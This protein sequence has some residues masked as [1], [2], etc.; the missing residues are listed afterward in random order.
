MGLSVVI[1]VYNGEQ[2]IERCL[3]SLINQTYKNLE[4][5]VVDDGSKDKSIDI[6]KN[7]AQK[8]KR[9]CL[10]KKENG[11]A[12]SARNYGLKKASQKYITF[13]DC[14]DTL[15][16]DMYEVLMKY[17]ES[18]KYDIVHC[19][20]KRIKDD[21]VIKEVN[22]TGKEYIQDNL[23]ALECLID[24]RLFV[25]ALWNKIYKRE[26]FNNIEF[27]ESLKMNE[28]ILVNYKVFN[29]SKKS[30]FI[31]IP[32]Y[33][34]YEVDTSACKTTFDKK[35]KI[36]GLKVSKQIYDDVDDKYLKNIS[37]NRYIGSLI[38]LYKYYLYSKEKDKKL[39]CKLI[40]E[41]IINECNENNLTS[42]R[43][44]ITVKL[45]CSSTMLYKII[46]YI[47]DK[48]RKPNWDV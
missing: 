10:Y 14:D 25:G 17:F 42:K 16:L 5:I 2:Y 28:D 26:L 4:I 35:K 44:K 37:F 45:I 21:K 29:V 34:Y 20:Y 1:P 40:K 38:G 33:N 19:G 18:G 43:D 13:V 47:Y 41:K 6:I 39:N 3:N 9:V 15:D 23:Q 22:G 36:D 32:K 48:I 27:D 11:G 24:G 31:D 8:D 30:I 46:Y 7:I 12:S